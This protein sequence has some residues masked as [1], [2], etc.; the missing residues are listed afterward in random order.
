MHKRNLCF[1]TLFISLC[2]WG[3]GNG[4]VNLNGKI[5]FSDDGSPLTIGTVYFASGSH[6]ARG[7]IDSNGTYQIGSHSQKDGL[8]PGTYRVYISGAIK[9]DGAGM[10]SGMG[11]K[12]GGTTTPLIDKKFTQAESSGIEVEVTSSLKTFDFKVDRAK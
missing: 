9:S 1:L 8:P 6:L 11:N 4:N 2:T 5:T 10:G 3:C 12:M 7:D